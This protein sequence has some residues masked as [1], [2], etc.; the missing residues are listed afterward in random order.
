MLLVPLN[1][2]IVNISEINVCCLKLSFVVTMLPWIFFPSIY[3]CNVCTCTSLCYC[4]FSFVP[5]MSGL[6][7]HVHHFLPSCIVYFELT[8]SGRFCLF[9][10]NLKH[11]QEMRIYFSHTYCNSCFTHIPVPFPHDFYRYV[12]N[13]FPSLFFSSSFPFY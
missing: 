9:L 5:Q 10:Y 2:V 11:F 1:K 4:A 12:S 7:V 8:Q 6:C 3:S 13:K